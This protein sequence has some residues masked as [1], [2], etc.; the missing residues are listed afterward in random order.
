MKRTLATAGL[1]AFAAAP[2]LHT[3]CGAAAYSW[4]VENA[5]H[6][7]KPASMTVFETS[8][9]TRRQKEPSP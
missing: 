5:I 2:R 8:K 1:L 9:T 7:V 6:Q 4:P 3:G